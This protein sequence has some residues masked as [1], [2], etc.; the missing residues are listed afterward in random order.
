ML[1][2]SEACRCF[3]QARGLLETLPANDTEV[4]ISRPAGGY[5]AGAESALTPL[6]SAGGVTPYDA[7]AIAGREEVWRMSQ[8]LSGPLSGV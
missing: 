7:R 5:R 3:H 8:Q 4:R 1:A 6:R 2:Y